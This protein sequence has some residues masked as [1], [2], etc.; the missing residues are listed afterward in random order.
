MCLSYIFSFIAILESNNTPNLCIAQ[1]KHSSK[2]IVG[3]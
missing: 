3:M 1:G 2:H